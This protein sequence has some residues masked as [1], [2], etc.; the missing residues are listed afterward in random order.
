M[1]KAN[2]DCSNGWIS[3]VI[4]VVLV[5]EVGSKNSSRPGREDWWTRPTVPAIH[6]KLTSTNSLR[7]H[8]LHPRRC[9]SPAMVLIQKCYHP[10]SSGDQETFVA[11]WEILVLETIR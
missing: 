1:T 7:R 5:I 6:S 4:S 8:L 11:I 9:S 2:D 3:F 10:D